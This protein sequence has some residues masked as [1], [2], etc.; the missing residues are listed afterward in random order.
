[1]QR[2]L[3]AG[4]PRVVATATEYPRYVIGS[5]ETKTALRY[6]FGSTYPELERLERMV[7]HSQIETRH[8]AAPLEML[9]AGQSLETAN[10]IYV[11]TAQQ[12]GR[13]VASQALNAAGVAADEV[14]FVATISCTGYAI[15]SLDVHLANRLGLR[16]DVRR[17]PI[18]ELGCGGGAAGLSL[19]G[20]WVR[21]H[22]GSTAL[23][24]SV[25]LCSLTFQ[26]ADSSSSNV[27][28]ALLFGDGAA[29]AVVTSRPLRP[30]PS[31]VDSRTH[32]YPNTEHYMGFALKN[33]GFHL[34]MSPEVPEM[35]RRAFRPQLTDFLA[36]AG[37]TQDCLGFYVLHPGGSKILRYY[38]SPVGVPDVWL[39]PAADVLGRS[40][41]MSS[42]TVLFVLDE[43]MRHQ[44]PSAGNYGLLASLGP[45]FCTE[46]VLLRWED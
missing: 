32:L 43:V 11:E 17:L 30:G 8:L 18:T 29:A 16:S 42:A 2:S 13:D 40:G 33:S 7:D 27:I 4:L 39:R 26:P 28:A 10:Q 37:L 1:M 44:A 15:P 22:P 41:N 6:A 12:L 35:V 34:Q 31:I 9:L 25:E 14:D 23:L 3:T 38:R 24:V 36:S 45:G 20:D 21:A 19:T 5:D 46:L